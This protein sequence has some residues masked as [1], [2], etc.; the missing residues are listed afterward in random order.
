MRSFA[1]LLLLSFILICYGETCPG[2]TFKSAAG[3]KAATA[4]VTS[5]RQINQLPHPIE[6]D[7]PQRKYHKDPMERPDQDLPVPMFDA[8]DP[9]FRQDLYEAS[10][11]SRDV[12]A[13]PCESFIGILDTGWNP[14]D[15]DVA[16]GPDHVVEVVNSSIAI[17][18]KHTG[19]KLMQSTAAFWF[20]GTN[21]APPSSFIYDPKV[22]YDPNGGR[23]IILYL[24]TDDVSESSYLVSVSSTSDAMDDWYSYNFDATLNGITPTSTWPDYPGLGFDFDQAVYVTSNQWVFN[25]GFI[26]SK[27][28][29][30]PKAQLYAGLNVSFNDLWDLR[31]NDNGVAFTVKP[32][33]T[34][35]DADGE[36]LLSNVWFGGTYTTYWKI[37]DPILNPAVAVR[38]RVNVPSYPSPPNAAQLGGSA[39][40]TIGAMTQEVIFRNGKVYTSFDQRVNWGSGNV[41]AVRVLGV[42]TASSMATVDYLFGADG[43]HYFFPAV[44]VDPNDVIYLVCNRS[45]TNEY[46][47][48]HYVEDLANNSTSVQV[49]AGESTRSGSAPVRWGDY[50]G[51]SPDGADQSKAWVCMEYPSQFS[52][53]WYTWIGQA[54][55]QLIGANPLNPLDQTL[56]MLPT[57]VEWSSI[58]AA[59][60]YQLQIAEDAGFATLA[61]DVV[62]GD[63][64][65]SAASLT[66]QT[67]YF[68]RV[69]ALGCPNNPWTPTQEF[70]VCNFVAGDADASGIASVGDAVFVIQYIFGGGPAPSPLESGDVNCDGAVTIADAVYLVNFI[71]GGGPDLCGEC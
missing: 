14:P 71:F 6:S 49:K 64:S 24:C 8:A 28:R 55:S 66:D 69:R 50:A 52:S 67:T 58:A 26:Y 37:T 13:A 46:V 7:K 15:P 48:V 18:D 38:P 19:Q 3:E 60:E 62:V 30:L 4:T 9:R 61:V 54:P 35:S 31:E 39:I 68:W 5:P 17:F 65:Y 32:A 20:S 25:G 63:T 10:E 16:V 70:R 40:G 22:V 2:A 56:T 41:S 34:Y 29:I 51:I 57:Q 45:A 1:A 47:S 53:T 21:P 43:K 12:A 23:F 44:Y 59:Q 11:S 42:D 33:S 27:V 36:F